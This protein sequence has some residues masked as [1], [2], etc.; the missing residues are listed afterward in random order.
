MAGGNTN[1]E[2]GGEGMVWMPVFFLN[3][4]G[5][6]EGGRGKGGS[7]PWLSDWWGLGFDGRSD[8]RSK[9]NGSLGGMEKYWYTYRR[10]RRLD[11]NRGRTIR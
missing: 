10:Y 2:K 3:W 8:G 6:R 4:L 5:G 9:G 1:V 11:G 7:L